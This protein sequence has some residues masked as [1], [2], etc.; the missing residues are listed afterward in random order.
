MTG[1]WPAILVASGLLLT[2]CRGEE[3]AAA[4]AV[5]A[6]DEAIIKVYRGNDLSAMRGLATEEE[7]NRLTVLVDLKRAGHLTLMSELQRFDARK[8]ELGP[9]TATVTTEE[10]WRYF[11]RP[12]DPKLPSGDTFL[13]DMVLEYSLV[14]DGAAWKVRKARTLSSNYLEPKGF[15]PGAAR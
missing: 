6:Y 1:R 15:Q 9:G 11:D 12:D 14:K 5:R 10:R 8:V 7:V 2:A 13:A 4:A 3:R